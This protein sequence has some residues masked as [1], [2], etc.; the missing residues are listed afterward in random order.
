AFIVAMHSSLLQPHCRSGKDQWGGDSARAALPCLR[1]SHSPGGWPFERRVVPERT[2]RRDDANDPRT[3]PVRLGWLGRKP[4]R[5]DLGDD[6]EVNRRNPA[7]RQRWG[8]T[9]Q[10]LLGGTLATSTGAMQTA[11]STAA[12]RF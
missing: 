4:S 6:R 7:A 12:A 8:R 9:G 3:A 1:A 10:R 5:H 2:Q 11:T